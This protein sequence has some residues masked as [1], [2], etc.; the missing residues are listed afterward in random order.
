[1][2]GY[3]LRAVT[4]S[5]DG[6]SLPVVVLIRGDT[7]VGVGSD[8][9][10]RRAIVDGVYRRF[11]AGDLRASV[12]LFDPSVV[13]VVDDGIPDGGT[14]VGVHGVRDYMSRFLDPWET[15]TISADS[16]ETVGDTLLVRAVREVRDVDGDATS[17]AG[18]TL[19]SGRSG[20]KPSSGL[21]W[22]WTRRGR[23]GC[24]AWTADSPVGLSP[25]KRQR[26]PTDSHHR[27]GG[28]GT[29]SCRQIPRPAGV[30]ISLCRGITASAG[31]RVETSPRAASPSGPHP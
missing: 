10:T 28:A 16:I 21:K 23:E 8:G 3:P 25:R 22:F 30:L 5:K 31:R 13:L 2:V 20:A 11:A 26:R 29:P 27:N 24:S 9:E 14:Y 17:A 18:P 1:M 6:Q 7:H 15:L 4:L 19:S 12:A